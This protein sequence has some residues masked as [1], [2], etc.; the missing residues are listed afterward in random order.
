MKTRYSGVLDA[1]QR[2]GMVVMQ[3]AVEKSIE[4]AKKHGIGAIGINNL[5][6]STGCLGFW[7]EKPAK[8]GLIAII[9]A[10]SPPLTAPFGSSS[11]RF[12]VRILIPI[13][14]RCCCLL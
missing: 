2:N 8:E 3:E 14:I 7:A 10:S 5:S 1:G 13:Y 9:M 4:L 11:P 12:G 6:S